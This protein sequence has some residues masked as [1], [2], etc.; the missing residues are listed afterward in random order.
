[1]AVAISFPYTSV[2]SSFLGPLLNYI[3][4]PPLQDE[5]PCGEDLMI[6]VFTEQVC[7]FCSSPASSTLF[8]LLTTTWIQ[9][10]LQ[11]TYKNNSEQDLEGQEGR[12]LVTDRLLGAVLPDELKHSLD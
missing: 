2:L 9:Y 12:S 7:Y 4:Q 1:M 10:G 6:R 3:T 8:I 5:L 11:Q